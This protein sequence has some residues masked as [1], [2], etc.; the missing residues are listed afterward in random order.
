MNFQVPEKEIRGSLLED[1]LLVMESGEFE[2]VKKA[3]ER[4][5]KLLGEM[6]NFEKALFTVREK[7]RQKCKAAMEKNDFAAAMFDDASDTVQKMMWQSIRHRLA[8]RETSRFGI[9]R[10]WQIVIPEEEPCIGIG[11]MISG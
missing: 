6:N 11:F 9:R 2:D 7:N 5:E 8:S 1:V 3:A 4:D 10:G